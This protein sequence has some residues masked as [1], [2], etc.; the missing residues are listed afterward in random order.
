MITPLVPSFIR[1]PVFYKSGMD[2][3]IITETIRSECL[4]YKFDGDVNIIL[5]FVRYIRNQ[6]SMDNCI[7]KAVKSN[8]LNQVRWDMSDDN[9]SLMDHINTIIHTEIYKHFHWSFDDYS[10]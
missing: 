1:D 3:D 9:E 6:H 4:G 10:D 2:H 8:T 7:C 5:R